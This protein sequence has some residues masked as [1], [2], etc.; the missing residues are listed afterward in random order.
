MKYNYV[1]EIWSE[2]YKLGVICGENFERDHENPIMWIEMMDGSHKNDNSFDW[3]SPAFFKYLFQVDDK[4]YVKK[5]KKDLK[6]DLLK[7]GNIWPGWFKE[8]KDLIK[9]AERQDMI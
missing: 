6:K 5:K 8:L 9:E 2:H 3:S 4:E 7:I 1:K